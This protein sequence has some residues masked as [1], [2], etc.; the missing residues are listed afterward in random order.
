VD[1]TA[2][3]CTEVVVVIF[4]KPNY[5]SLLAS[6]HETPPHET[7]SHS[8]KSSPHLRIGSSRM[9]SSYSASSSSMNYLGCYN[10]TDSSVEYII[11]SLEVNY[12][13]NDI[14]L[15]YP[16]NNDLPLWGDKVVEGTEVCDDGGADDGDG[17]NA[18]CQVETG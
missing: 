8:F 4:S 16:L 2:L 6:T 10:C 5:Y 7:V 17:C 1:G 14:Y 11:H 18:T 15:N 3:F 12:A 13:T 9:T